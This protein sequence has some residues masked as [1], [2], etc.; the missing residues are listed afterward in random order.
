[1]AARWKLVQAF[2]REA[3]EDGAFAPVS[4][5][6]TAYAKLR[7]VQ[8]GSYTLVTSENGL[9]QI[10]SKIEGSE[11]QFTVP[12]GTSPG[13]IMEAAE[14]ALQLINGKTVA[15]AR[16]LLVRRK[17]LRPDFRFLNAP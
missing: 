1:M 12:D 3:T 11:F 14:T 6:A 8:R 16:A 13:E 17:T 4:D 7:G 2:I 5:I 15:Q 10:L 9:L